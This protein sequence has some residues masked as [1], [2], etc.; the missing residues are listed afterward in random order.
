MGT[1]CQEYVYIPLGGSHGGLIK[2]LLNIAAVWLL[3]G[4][5]YGANWNFVLWGVY[6]GRC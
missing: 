3:T 6:F 2:Q 4:F 1:W 5:W